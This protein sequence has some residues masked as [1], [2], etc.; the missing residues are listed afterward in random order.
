MY[1]LPPIE[2]SYMGAHG[3]T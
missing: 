3:W 2:K 1:I